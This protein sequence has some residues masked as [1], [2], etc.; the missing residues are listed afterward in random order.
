MTDLGWAMQS[1]ENHR[2]RR[3]PN[4][5]IWTQPRTISPSFQKQTAKVSTLPREP[6]NKDN[7]MQR[8][9]VQG[10][11]Q[12]NPMTRP[13][14]SSGH[15]KNRVLDWN[16]PELFDL[17]GTFDMTDD[18]T[19]A[20]SPPKGI[21]SMIGAAALNTPQ[22][23]EP[24]HCS[25]QI[26]ENYLGSLMP[27]FTEDS[28]ED[29]NSYMTD[30]PGSSSSANSNKLNGF[31]A[32]HLAAYL[33]KAS[34]VRLL[35]SACPEAVDLT[36]SDGETPLHVAASEG[37]FE[38]AVELLRAGA[39]TIM[40]DVDGRTVLHIAVCK[41]YLDIVQLLIDGHN[42]QSMIRLT[43]SA[44]RTP[45]HQAVLQGS[46]QI[47]QLFLEKGADPRMPIG[48][49]SSSSKLDT[50]RANF[51]NRILSPNSILAAKQQ[52]NVDLNTV[53]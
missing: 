4:K 19:S 20:P 8:D 29:G 43:D 52:Q 42:G 53:K 28:V 25:M 6:S 46:D 7:R 35:L 32:I 18:V 3:T 2:R 38:V 27:V 21:S 10:K 51:L 22:S 40:Q 31:S 39:S 11:Q 37:R 9:S 1:S 14:P 13:F 16:D 44:G 48:K 45:L 49:T 23:M 17:D 30:G 15:T 24:Q 12:Q 41:E 47:V 33:G 34:V 36:N 5:L 26:E 50:E